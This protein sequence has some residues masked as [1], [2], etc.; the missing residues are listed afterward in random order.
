MNAIRSRLSTSLQLS[1]HV[2]Y[3]LESSER[4]A[5]LDHSVS[6]GSAMGSSVILLE[7]HVGA[8]GVTNNLT[9]LQPK[10]SGGFPSGD[11]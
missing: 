11:E 6:K 7:L 8:A 2:S 5:Q 4:M 3:R 1:K 9:T 10:D